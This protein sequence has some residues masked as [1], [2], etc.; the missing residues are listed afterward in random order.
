[1]KMYERGPIIKGKG[2]GIS[3]NTSVQGMSIEQ[4]I[5]RMMQ[6]REP[7]DG[8]QAPLIYQERNEGIKAS[9]DI[10]TDRFE[11]AIEAADKIAKSYKARREEKAPKD[12]K[13]DD[14][15]PEPID[16]KAEGT[17]PKSEGK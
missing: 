17:Q 16:T 9:M 14:G 11:V 10:R 12:D 4:K 3:R 8:D 5:E 15:K 13:K 7:L 1:M 2:R 6:Q